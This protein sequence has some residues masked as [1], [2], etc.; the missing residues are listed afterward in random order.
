MLSKRIRELRKA[1]GLS[2]VELG[3][4]LSVS[5][6]TVSNWENNNVMPSIEMLERLADFFNVKTD[7]LLCR[8][9]HRCINVGEL[10]PEEAAHISLIVSDLKNSTPDKESV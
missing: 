10:T 8:E 9:S 6:Q 5:K 7:Y 4:K 2:V 3:E 1:S